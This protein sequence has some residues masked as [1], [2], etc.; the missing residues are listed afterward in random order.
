FDFIGSDT[1]LDGGPGRSVRDYLNGRI[2]RLLRRRFRF[3]GSM[4]R[5]KLIG[6]LSKS[7]LAVV[8]SQW[9]NLPYS[10]IEAMCTGLPVLVS[11]TGGMAEL[12]ADNESGWVAP[13]TTP[14]GLASALRRFLDT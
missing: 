8:P 6:V 5:E 14:A 3:H 2:P 9:E 1:S 12:I 10:C 7:P 13:E 11:P 4:S